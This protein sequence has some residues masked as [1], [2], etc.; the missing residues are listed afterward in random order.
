MQP[1]LQLAAQRRVHEPVPRHRVLPLE[2][3]RHGV[4]A[5]VRLRVGMARGIARVARVEVGL[6]GDGEGDRGE[7]GLELAGLWEEEVG[8]EEEV[9]EE[10]EVGRVFF[11][12]AK[13]PIEAFA[14]N[15]TKERPKKLLSHVLIAVSTGPAIAAATARRMRK[16]A[17]GRNERVSSAKKKGNVIDSSFDSSSLSLLDRNKKRKKASRFR[18]RGSEA[19]ASAVS[20]LL[21]RHR[22]HQGLSRW[23]NWNGSSDRATERA[24]AFQ[25]ARFSSSSSSATSSS[26]SSPP[27]PPGPGLKDFLPPRPTG[28]W[29]PM[30][31][32]PPRQAI[33]GVSHIIA[34]SSGKGGVGKSTVAVNLAV[35]LSRSGLRTS[36][37]DADVH[38]PSVPRLL[39]LAGRR[40]E[41]DD[42]TGKIIPLES[43]CSGGSGS[44]GSGKPSSFPLRSLSMGNLVDEGAAAVWR[45]PMV[46]SA[47]ETLTRKADWRGTDV[48]VIDM[49][50]G[51]GDAHLSVAQRLPLAGAIAVT[52]PQRVALDDVARGVRGWEA[53]GVRLLGVVENMSGFACSGCGRV[54][55]VFGGGIGEENGSEKSETAASSAAALLGAPLLASV[56]LSRALRVSCDRGEPIVLLSEAERGV[57]GG[58]RASAEA[59]EALAARVRGIL[60]V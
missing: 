22:H 13:S 50:P 20:A 25:F 49:P 17:E 4:D 30:P 16:S 31:P 18:M 28:A 32:P 11:S 42:R 1:R 59:L 60:G 35:A 23:L 26:S 41:V 29:R 44:S 52:T 47:I 19:A 2:G 3:L 45:G 39:G 36:L 12:E 40:A 58:A 10:E 9:G 57:D 37:V 5:E 53:A 7:R 34:V 54:D 27:P 38:G 8:R 15:K 55:D 43:S 56:P 48:L 33:Q 24:Q 46:M 51:T 14:E 21:R 6:V